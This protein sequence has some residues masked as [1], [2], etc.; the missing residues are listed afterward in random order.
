M[1]QTVSLD[2]ISKNTLANKG[3]YVPPPFTLE[4]EQYIFGDPA[5][6]NNITITLTGVS[7]PVAGA[8]DWLGKPS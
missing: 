5:A 3:G 2:F 6:K 8:I 7:S 1:N 4:F